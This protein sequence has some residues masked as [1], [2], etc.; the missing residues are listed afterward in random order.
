MGAA[1]A[2]EED[3]PDEEGPWG[4]RNVGLLAIVVDG[5]GRRYGVDIG[6]EKEKVDEDVCELE[7]NP[8][9]PGGWPL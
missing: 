5:R 6:A 9:L 7:E 4:R 2:T 1:D 3:A 8:I